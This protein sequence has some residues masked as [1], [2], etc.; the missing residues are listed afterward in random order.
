MIQSR[1][2]RD[3]KVVDVVKGHTVAGM[4]GNNTILL[5]ATLGRLIEA[6]KGVRYLGFMAW[7]LSFK[8]GWSGVRNVSWI[9]G[10]TS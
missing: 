9:L 7:S 6:Q 5:Y 4:Q 8:R 1:P 3:V 2:D 10:R